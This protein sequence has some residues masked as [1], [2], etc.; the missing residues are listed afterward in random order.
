MKNLRGFL[1]G[2][3]NADVLYL[4]AEAKVRFWVAEHAERRVLPQ[5]AHQG[6]LIGKLRR[7][8][9]A[10]VTSLT[11]GT[12]SE[13]LGTPGMESCRPVLGSIVGK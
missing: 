13:G 4:Q 11:K 3:T 10:T 12:S 8:H 2:S 9:S 1:S 7:I 6:T 5:P